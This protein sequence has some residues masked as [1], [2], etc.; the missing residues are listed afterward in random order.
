MAD[1]SWICASRTEIWLY[2][3]ISGIQ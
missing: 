1:F 2:S 3:T